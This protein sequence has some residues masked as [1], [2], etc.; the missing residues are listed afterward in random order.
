MD[1]GTAEANTTL[2]PPPRGFAAWQAAW[3]DLGDNPLVQYILLAERRRRRRTQR[4]RGIAYFLIVA[5]LA[6]PWLIMLVDQSLSNGMDWETV[7]TWGLT[8]FALLYAIW[9]AEGVFNTVRDALTVLAPPSK[10]TTSLA[11]DDTLASSSLSDEEIVAGVLRI[12]LPPL[13]RRGLTGSALLWAGVMMAVTEGFSHW[14]TEAEKLLVLLPLAILLMAL[15]SFLGA[16]ALVL[17]Y[18]AASQTQHVLALSTGAVVAVLGQLAWVGIGPTLA[19]GEIALLEEFRGIGQSG[20]LG[21]GLIGMV[22]STTLIGLMALRGRYFAPLRVASAVAGPWLLPASLVLILLIWQIV[23]EF[24]G[25]LGQEERFAAFALGFAQGW[26]GT[27]VFN[28]GAVFSALFTGILDARPET[29]WQLLR[30]P[31]S[32]LMQLALVAAL[33]WAARDSVRRRRTEGARSR[34]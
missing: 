26:G 16:A 28:S 29:Y 9:L 7:L 10:L 4:Q 5:I 13:L 6:V 14:S 17:F 32:F 19:F 25:M 23:L 33:A 11:L 22:L 30:I 2:P 8:Y 34:G 1:L 15:S 18:L 31:A 27:L 20:A 3:R 21:L 12:L 24:S